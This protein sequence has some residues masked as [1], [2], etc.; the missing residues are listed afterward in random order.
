MTSD[1]KHLLNAAADAVSVRSVG[2]L[3]DVKPFDKE[4]LV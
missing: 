1:A 3:D 2:F 4:K